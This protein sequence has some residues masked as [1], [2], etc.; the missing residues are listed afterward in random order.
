MSFIITKKVEFGPP[1]E[2]KVVFQAVAAMFGKDK[3]VKVEV[4]G[5]QVA[6]M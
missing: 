3:A 4:D 6:E 2:A 5:I 1:R